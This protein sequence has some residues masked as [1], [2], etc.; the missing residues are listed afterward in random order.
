MPPQAPTLGLLLGPRRVLHV[1][2][3]E[4]SSL[5]NAM[6]DLRY[7][8]GDNIDAG[9]TVYTYSVQLYVRT[10]RHTDKGRRT[11]FQTARILYLPS[12]CLWESQTQGPVTCGTEV[13]KRHISY[14]HIIVLSLSRCIFYRQPLHPPKHS[15]L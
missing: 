10:I 6:F 2:A 7:C 13:D 15:S 5:G 3:V 8:I 11:D 9:E 12:I 4:P 14:C 1:S